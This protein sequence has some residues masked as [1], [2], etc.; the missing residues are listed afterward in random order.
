MTSYRQIKT[1][2]RDKMFKILSDINNVILSNSNNLIDSTN[3]NSTNNCIDTHNNIKIATNITNLCS[4]IIQEDDTI[5]VWGK[6]DKNFD[7][8]QNR[9]RHIS[10]QLDTYRSNVDIIIIN[11]LTESKWKKIFLNALRSAQKRIILIFPDTIKSG[12]HIE[13]WFIN[14]TWK[15][16]TENNQCVYVL[17]KSVLT[18]HITRKKLAIIT[19]IFSNCSMLREPQCNMVDDVDFYCF[20]DNVVE[21]KYMENYSY[22]ISL[23]QS[24]ND[25][26]GKNSLSN[27]LPENINNMMAAKYYKMNGHK[28]DILHEYEKI[29]WIDGAIQI[30]NKNLCSDILELSQD[31]HLVVFKHPERT[32]VA[33]ELNVSIGQIRYRQ[34]KV[35]EQYD[36]YKLDQFRII[37]AYMVVQ[38]RFEIKVNL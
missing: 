3:C 29:M 34:Q 15:L 5:E 18:R 24:S 7:Y 8:I 11:E 33:T 10:N 28:I 36:Q 32:N 26:N 12:I 13:R 17:T 4:T 38:F 2:L 23:N 21:I 19:A 16:Y 31:K 1:N 27:T 14:W 9:C 35:N 25:I 6:W 22:T 30:T 20:T 37:L